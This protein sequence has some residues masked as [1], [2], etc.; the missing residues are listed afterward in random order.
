MNRK[1]T[2]LTEASLKE[3]FEALTKVEAQA[4]KREWVM[5]TGERGMINF[6][7]AMMGIGFPDVKYWLEQPNKGKVVAYFSLF[8]KHG[9][10]KV[11][12]FRD[13]DSN[14]VYQALIGTKVIY[15]YKGTHSLNVT[16]NRSDIKKAVSKLIEWEN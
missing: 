4:P 8:Q 7:F 14:L 5:I 15:E 13:K 3:F 6:H 1:Y 12:I 10:K 16:I 9:N 11:K 2:E